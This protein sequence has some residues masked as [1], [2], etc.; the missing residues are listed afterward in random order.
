MRICAIDPVLAGANQNANS[1][2]NITA[3][4]EH[5][6]DCSIRVMTAL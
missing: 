1:I 3:D 4:F 6:T 2:V 5:C